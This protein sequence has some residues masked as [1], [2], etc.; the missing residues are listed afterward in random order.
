MPKLDR[1][2][3]WNGNRHTV[4]ADRDGERLTITVDGRSSEFMIVPGADG[5]FV[6]Q[7]GDR[8]RTGH[9]VARD[10]F[11][12]V[13][14]GGR[15]WVLETEKKQ[16]GRSAAGGP[17]HDRV[18]SPMVGTVRKI[19]VE[20]GAVLESGAPILI[21]EAMK[22]E[23]TVTAPAAGTVKGLLCSV[24][25]SVDLGELLADFEPAVQTPAP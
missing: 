21:V 15:T 23:F 8:I 10:G 1:H 2:Y 17:A 13:Q 6:L 5:A 16:R 3:L 9:A 4:Q 7:D 14:I 19:M 25:Q 18:V 20:A 22:M 12:W 24:G 11:V